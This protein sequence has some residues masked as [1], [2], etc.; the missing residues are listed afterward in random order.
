MFSFS[1]AGQRAFNIYCAALGALDPN[2]LPK[3]PT[4]RGYNFIKCE[5][6]LERK[7]K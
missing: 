6:K 5:A 2:I 3:L 4:N 1:K 7:I